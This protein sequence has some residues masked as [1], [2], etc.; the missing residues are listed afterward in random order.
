VY[1]PQGWISPV[2]LVNGRMHGCWHYRIRGSRVAVIIEPF[3]GVPIWVRRAADQE[4]ARLAAFLGCTL[5]V[6]WKG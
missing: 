4:A 3:D 5:S 2:L 6:E 1:R